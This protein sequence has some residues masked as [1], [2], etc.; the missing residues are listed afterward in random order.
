MC[1][2]DR[3]Q[4][5]P[6][7]SLSASMRAEVIMPRSPTITILSSPKR[8]LSLSTAETNALG[9]A[10]L[11]GMKPVHR[12][13]DVV[14]GGAVNAK[15]LGQGR[16]LPPPRGGELGARAHDAGD[17][18]RER[19]ITLS[20]CGTEQLGQAELGRHRGDRGDVA[21]GQ[22]ALDLEGARRRHEGLPLECPADDLDYL[23]GQ[24]REVA[25]RLALDLALF[26]VRAPQ[27]VRLIG[28]VLVVPTR[29]GHMD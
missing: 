16:V 21:V 3:T 19:E 14:G 23:C 15:V 29:S 17:Y 24:M 11:P 18:Q 13:V 5:M 26:A 1:I 27:Q 7:I 4:P 25:D 10:V 12:A 20:S 2:R 22:G 8:C 9:S 28:L 6:P